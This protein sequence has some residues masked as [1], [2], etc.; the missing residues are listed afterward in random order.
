MSPSTATNATFAAQPS[1]RARVAVRVVR[2]RDEPL[3][4]RRRRRAPS[5]RT[6][7]SSSQRRV[8][9]VRARFVARA[10]V[11]RFE[12][13]FARAPSDDRRRRG[14]FPRVRVRTHRVAPRR[15]ASPPHAS[16]RGVTRCVRSRRDACAW[17]AKR[18][19][20]TRR[21]ATRARERRM[22]RSRATRT[23]PRGEGSSSAASRGRR[24]AAT[25]P[26]TPTSSRK[27]RRRADGAAAD[28][29]VVASTPTATKRRRVPPKVTSP[30]DRNRLTKLSPADRRK[31]MDRFRAQ[32]RRRADAVEALGKDWT[33]SRM[34]LA[35][36][37]PLPRE[38]NAE[39]VPRWE[40]S[41]ERRA[42][43]TGGNIFRA[44][45]PTVET[46]VRQR[47][48]AGGGDHGDRVRVLPRF[49]AE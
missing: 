44:Q 42:R 9:L 10:A 25:S 34:A 19:T 23:S 43:L 1:S 14:A 26:T 38:G 49:Q 39:C 36:T 17:D 6:F 11:A 35:I 3:F 5:H 45:R 4:A 37:R 28:A 13:E 30:R 21:N 2:D 18:H 47:V 16:R 12:F 31:E 33:S 27:R 7:A 40:R 29:G 15:D 48:R 46:R 32:A 8:A 20:T 24:G 22:T 41:T